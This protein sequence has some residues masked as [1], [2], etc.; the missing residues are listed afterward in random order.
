MVITGLEPTGTFGGQKFRGGQYKGRFKKTL[1][2]R[3]K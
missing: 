1:V 2:D 3:V